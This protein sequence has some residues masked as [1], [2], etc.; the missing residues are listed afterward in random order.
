V[1]ADR[2]RRNLLGRWLT[3]MGVNSCRTTLESTPLSSLTPVSG[4]ELVITEAPAEDVD[5]QVIAL[6][7]RGWKNIVVSTPHIDAATAGA[8]LRRDVRVLMRRDRRPPAA[9]NA[10]VPSPLSHSD[11]NS[12]PAAESESAHELTA[13]LTER[14]RAVLQLVAQGQSNREIG[15]TLGLSHLTIKSHLSRV[16]RKLGTGDR[17]SMVLIALRG[18]AI[19]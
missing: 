3:L 15:S 13:Q 7:T 12:S 2:D 17:A 1:L 18:G 14:E 8:A 5:T 16:S 4:D 9:L 6:R 10:A 19:A 11:A